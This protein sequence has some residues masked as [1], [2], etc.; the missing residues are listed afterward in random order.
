MPGGMTKSFFIKVNIA[1]RI[2]VSR[3]NLYGWHCRLLFLS[4]INKMRY[5]AILGRYYA[6][7][8]IC[9]K[10]EL[11]NSCKLEIMLYFLQEHKNWKEKSINCTTIFKSLWRVAVWLIESSLNK[12]IQLLGTN[13]RST[14]FR[15]CIYWC[16]GGRCAMACNDEDHGRSRRP[17]TEDRG[18]SHKL[19]TQWSCDREVGWRCVRSAPCTLRWEARVSWLSLKTKVDSLWVV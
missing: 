18:W 1:W 7:C 10:I 9:V 14:I 12:N 8:I 16:V 3:C 4:N 11:D 2:W 17:G 19:D 15:I 13:F 5:E 6:L